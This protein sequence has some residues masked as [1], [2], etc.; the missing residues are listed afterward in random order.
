MTQAL[1]WTRQ[2]FAL[3]HGHSEPDVGLVWHFHGHV[4]RSFGA[5][6]VIVGCASVYSLEKLLG[7]AYATTPLLLTPSAGVLIG[8]AQASTTYA[9]IYGVIGRNVAASRRSWAMGIAA[10]AGSF[11]QFLMVRHRACSSATLAGNE[12]WCCWVWRPC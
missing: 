9:V 10:A 12:P 7:M 11:G 2:D 1:D 4:G 6:K 3:A 8:L 5:F